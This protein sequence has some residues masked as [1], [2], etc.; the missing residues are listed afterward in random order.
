MI[1]NAKQGWDD[2]SIIEGRDCSSN[3]I[4][5]RGLDLIGGAAVFPHM[6][7]D[8]DELLDEQAKSLGFPLVCLSDEESCWIEDGRF[9][10]CEGE[11]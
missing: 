7:S 4:G 5:V 2:P 1:T 8:Y 11:H 9:F 6:S 10:L 3:W